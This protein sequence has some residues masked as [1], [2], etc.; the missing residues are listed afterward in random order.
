MRLRTTGKRWT[1]SWRS[2]SQ[3]SAG[4]DKPGTGLTSGK[5]CFRAQPQ[6]WFPGAVLRA[7]SLESC[8]FRVR[9]PLEHRLDERS[10]RL[11]RRL[12]DG[13]PK[14]GV[15]AAPPFGGGTNGSVTGACRVILHALPLTTLC[16]SAA[17][18]KYRLES[19]LRA[20]SDRNAAS[21]PCREAS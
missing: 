14:K 3:T 7:A 12:G 11:A 4:T 17:Y 13:A 16:G 5:S 19:A 20:S 10:R 1:R 9:Q 21:Q 6:A 2:G 15:V 18:A 8:G